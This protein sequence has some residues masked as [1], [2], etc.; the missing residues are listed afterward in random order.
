MK[1]LQISYSL[2]SGGGERFVVDLSNELSKNNEVILL[3]IVDD[4]PVQNRHYLSDLSAKVQYL[5]IKAKSGLHIKSFF[6]VYKAIKRIK[7]DIVHS[8]CT[9]L[10]LYLPALFLRKFCYVYTFHSLANLC[11]KLKAQK[12]IDKFFFH[13]KII[14][15]VTI[16]RECHKSFVEIYKHSYD[17]EIVNGRS[18]LT[19]TDKYDE[20]TQEIKSYKQH[21]DDKIFIHI[22]RY[23][24]IKNQEMLFKAFDRIIKENNNIQ[25]LVIGNGFENA[26]ITSN[27]NKKHIHIL[28]EKRNIGDYLA[29]SDFFVLTSLIEGLPLS[30]LEAMSFGVI[31]ISTPAGGVKDVI[32]NGK[33]GFISPS[34][35]CEDFIQTIK[36]A[37][38]DEK[39]INR[40]FIKDEYETKY[41]M[42]C[43][44]QKYQ[45]T[46]HT[47]INKYHTK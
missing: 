3:T 30:L 20:V 42:S 24:Y 7:P 2:T 15:P 46:Y 38:M 43:C 37:L 35:D 44:A 18:K 39:N 33:T 29:S 40:E 21:D 36:R 6:K 31:P 8:H 23:H 17:I 12:Y 10:Q 4:T 11:L 16:S 19:L 28:G 32:I 9:M 13:K 22:A 27:I 34:F 26:P 45:S 25:L 47:I 1:I 14:I 41:S 5:N